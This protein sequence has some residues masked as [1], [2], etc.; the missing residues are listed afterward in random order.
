M[1]AGIVV[2]RLGMQQDGQKYGMEARIV[3]GQYEIQHGS[4]NSSRAVR[5]AAGR[6]E[7]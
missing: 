6:L 3:V 5:N 1:Q 7:I 4:W 2:G